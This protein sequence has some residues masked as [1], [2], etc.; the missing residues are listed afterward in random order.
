MKS[1][2][3]ISFAALLVL[4]I[5]LVSLYIFRAELNPVFWGTNAIAAEQK[6]TAEVKTEQPVAVREDRTVDLEVLLQKKAELKVQEEDLKS[7]R[8]DIDI[9]IGKLTKLR[10]EIKND[11]ARKETIEGQSLKHLIKAY[12]AMKPQ[13]AAEVI[14]KLDKSFAVEL[15]SQMKGESVGAILSF[16]DREKAARIVEGLAQR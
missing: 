7:I 15:L 5:I 10:A 13:S 8:D 2:T 16:M 1:L 6:T 4:K 3:Y 11:L 9:K 12:S 14:G